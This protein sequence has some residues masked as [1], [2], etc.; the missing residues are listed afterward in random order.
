MA[1]DYA[2]LDLAG[3][4][5]LV[6]GSP[7]ET[8]LGLTAGSRSDPATGYAGSEAVSGVFAPGDGLPAEWTP[9]V[10]WQ[11]PFSS[12]A[13]AVVVSWD[14]SATEDVDPGTYYLYLTVDGATSLVGHIN[15]IAGV[16]SAG[17]ISPA[18]LIT[19]TEFKARCGS[20]AESLQTTVTAAGLKRVL[21]L[22]TADLHAAI[23]D[24]YSQS[25]RGG[26]SEA[27]ARSDMQT[28]LATP[29]NL[30]VTHAMRDFVAYRA[31]WHLT[32]FTVEAR[33]SGGSVMRAAD[34]AEAE[35]MRAKRKV[36]AVVS[37]YGDPIVLGGPIRVRR[38]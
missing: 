36:V 10:A 9:T 23:V 5:P 13:P 14:A 6:A 26:S 32:R 15:L 1:N 28:S 27:T 12:A 7:F 20:W 2:P 16:D 24:R 29:A 3:G 21:S 18:P 31:L 25:F 17:T 30:T 11:S 8:T 19:I 38:G 22:A 33:E 4:V 34:R 35:A 37:G